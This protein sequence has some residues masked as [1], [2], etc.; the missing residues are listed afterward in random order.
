VAALECREWTVVDPGAPLAEHEQHLVDSL[1]KPEVRL[2][3][4]QQI[5]VLTA[6]LQAARASSAEWEESAAMACEAPPAGCVCPG[7]S[8]AR[9]RGTP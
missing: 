5:D 8:L 1:L 9:E 2:S 3:L 4:Q 7:C 6:E